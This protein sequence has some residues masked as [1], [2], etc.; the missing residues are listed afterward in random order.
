MMK[1]STLKNGILGLAA[2]AVLATPTLAAKGGRQFMVDKLFNVNVTANYQAGAH[3]PADLT[4]DVEVAFTGKGVADANGHTMVLTFDELV[5]GDDKAAVTVG[6]LRYVKWGKEY[7]GPG[8]VTLTVDG[9][10]KDVPVLARVKVRHNK[11]GHF[12]QV[13][14]QALDGDASFEFNLRGRGCEAVVVQ[15]PVE[16]TQL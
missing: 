1:K 3:T 12:T 14:L 6:E 8:S 11:H 16:P 5:S 13:K 2:V 15:P 4:D 9:A 7:R 10:T